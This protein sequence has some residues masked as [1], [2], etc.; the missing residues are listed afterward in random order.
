[1][2]TLTL[3]CDDEIHFSGF[4]DLPDTGEILVRIIKDTLILS[5]GRK[6][7]EAAHLHIKLKNRV[8]HDAELYRLV[9]YYANGD[10]ITFLKSPAPHP[11]YIQLSSK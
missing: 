11:E 6:S 5:L 10:T 4:R 3:G 1:M 8:A 2:N 7:S 9:Q